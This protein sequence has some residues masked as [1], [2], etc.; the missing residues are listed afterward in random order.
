MQVIFSLHQR[1]N[2]HHQLRD[3]ELTMDAE[4]EYKR[5]DY[6]KE[7]VPM[8]VTNK[9]Q[10]FFNALFCFSSFQTRNQKALRHVKICKTNTKKF[11]KLSE[12]SEFMFGLRNAKKRKASKRTGSYFI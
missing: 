3:A 11:S 7:S 10:A 8:R 2:N 9:R 1:L 12:T 4:P 5:A 6:L